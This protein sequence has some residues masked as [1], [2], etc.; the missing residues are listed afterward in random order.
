MTK[1]LWFTEADGSTFL[2]R[3]SSVDLMRDDDG[4]A[5]VLLRSGLEFKLPVTLSELVSR[6]NGAE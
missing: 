2:V 6:M 3:A 4:R 1:F 5:V